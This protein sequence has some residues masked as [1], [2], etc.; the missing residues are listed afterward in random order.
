MRTYEVNVGAGRVR[1]E[2]IVDSLKCI[3]ILCVDDHPL[4]RR[5]IATVIDDETDMKLV[6]MAATATQGVE[7]YRCHRPD[8][9]LMDLNLPD[10]N[11][12]SAIAAIRTEF[13]HARLIALTTSEG[14]YEIQ[15]ALTAGAFGFL[16]KSTSLNELVEVIRK[17]HAGRK[18]LPAKLAQNLADHFTSDRLTERELEVLERVA[19]GDRNRDICERLAIS[20]ET[21]KIHI[22]HIMAKLGAKDRTQAV[23]IA[24]RRGV[25]RM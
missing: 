6:A 11:G 20:Q 7:E 21:V 22:K 24:V 18:H 1:P 17:V 4:F 13:P 15:R 25:I 9:T 10:K 5:G 8:V 14:D 23:A 16:L 19:E 3:R 2:V 12:V